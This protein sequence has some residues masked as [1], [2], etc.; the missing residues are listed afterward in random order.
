MTEAALS[1]LAEA[2]GRIMKTIWALAE[3]QSPMLKFFQM[4]IQSSTYS[5][6]SIFISNDFH[7]LS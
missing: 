6:L 3:Y 4:L 1:H 2:E 7:I 5:I